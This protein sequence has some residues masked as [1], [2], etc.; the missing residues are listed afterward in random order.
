MMT[1]F[2]PDFGTLMIDS[3]IESVRI[4]GLFFSI[5]GWRECGD[6]KYIE[7]HIKFTQL[8]IDDCVGGYATS[9]LCEHLACL[10]IPIVHKRASHKFAELCASGLYVKPC[11]ERQYE[12]HFGLTVTPV[13]LIE[14]SLQALLAPSDL[15]L[16]R[17]QKAEQKRLKRL[18]KRQK[19]EV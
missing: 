10:E 6:G 4:K 15:D 9:L 5:A 14:D 16:A 8:V 13:H 1:D 18:E 11:L 19:I 7:S 12:D 17:I 2:L 3:G